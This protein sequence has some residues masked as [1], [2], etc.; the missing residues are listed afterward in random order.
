[1]NVR[2]LCLGIL[3]FS[4]TTGYD[5]RKLA[6]DGHFSHF[7]EA[8]YGS[9]YPALAQLT[10]EGLV[11]FR[12]EAIN[13]KPQRK[14]YTITEKGLAALRH[15]LYEIPGTDKFKSE[16]LFYSLFSDKMLPNHFE[17]LLR[18]KIIETTEKVERLGEAIEACNHEP[19]QFAI[20]YG[21]AINNAALDYLSK[22]LETVKRRRKDANVVNM[23]E[24]A[25]VE[26]E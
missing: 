21:I 11:T 12:E 7:C 13:G 24:W 1:M 26:N 5:I 8:S 16:F 19:S 18:R 23:R 22:H 10:D 6:T 2:T 15:T 4:D 3:S 20:G 17:T 25:E 14:I 9:I